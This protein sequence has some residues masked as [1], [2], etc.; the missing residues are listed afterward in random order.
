M[1][2]MIMRKR[3]LKL[4]NAFFF[5][6]IDYLLHLS[7]SC[8]TSNIFY[9]LVWCFSWTLIMESFL[10]IVGRKFPMAFQEIKILLQK[11]I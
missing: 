6:L 8:F 2:G 4:S 10:I 7:V 3:E 9:T 5:S 11:F 1:I